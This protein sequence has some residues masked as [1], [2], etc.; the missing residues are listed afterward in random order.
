[1]TALYD[2]T[3]LISPR[4]AVW[5]GDTAYHLASV[6]S[7]AAG[8]SVNLLALTMSP[9]TGTHADAYYHIADE[10]A[11]AAEMPLSAYLGPARV[12][13]THKAYGPL[14]PEDFPSAALRGAM[15][16]LIHTPASARSDET[17]SNHFAYLSVP[18]IEQLADNGCVLIGI[19]S[20]SVDAF[21]SQDLPC[22]HA[23]RRHGLVNLESLQ[24]SGVPDGDYELI[25]LPLRL[26]GAC[27]SPVRAVLRA[28]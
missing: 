15:R 7:R 26:D 8:S 17:W 24:L 16:L 11:S 6:M 5:P 12:V 28:L 25:A 13:T 23:L 22:H 2:I 4:T 1:M 14:L 27:A 10:G 20:P 3:R 9:H 21:D 19:D 18:L